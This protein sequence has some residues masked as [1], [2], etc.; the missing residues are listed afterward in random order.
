MSAFDPALAAAAELLDGRLTDP[1]G[2]L[3]AHDSEEGRVVR[4]FQPGA[5]AVEVVARDDGR[6]LASLQAAG[7]TGLFT[8]RLSEAVAYVLH[9]DWHGVVQETEDTYSF[10][11]MLGELDLH[12]FAEGA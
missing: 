11:L 9:I 2:F 12:L 6:P 5:R 10:G 4:T 3:G 8:G 1:F 7:D